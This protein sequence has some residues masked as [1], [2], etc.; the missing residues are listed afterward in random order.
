MN[1]APIRSILNL[2]VLALVASTAQAQSQDPNPY[3]LT[4][5]QAF[6]HESNVRRVTSDLAQGDDIS[7]TTLRAGVDQRIGRQRVE[8]AATV[9]WVRFRRD[10]T[11]DNTGYRVNAQWDWSTIDHL[12]GE[13]GGDALQQL[14]RYDTSTTTALTDRNLEKT[15]HFFARARYGVVTEWTLLAEL[16][17]LNRQFSADS[18]ASRNQRRDTAQVGARYQPTPDL[19]FTGTLRRAHGEYPDY[20]T[21]QGADSYDRT[22]Y[23]GAARWQVSGASLLDVRLAWSV[24]DHSQQSARTAKLWSGSAGWT[25]QPT[26]KL[27]L[28]TR[29][30]RD[31]DTGSES[32][33]QGVLTSFSDARQS[34]ALDANLTWLATSKIRAYTSLRM[35]RRDLDGSFNG[36]LLTQTGKDTT[37]LWS[38]GVSYQVLRNAQLGC[39]GSFEQRKA[40]GNYLGLTYPYTAKVASCSAVVGW[41]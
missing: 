11:L 41:F 34:T 4:L 35:T 5:G 18:Y 20:S 24:E 25:W 3:S 23:E 9:D 19:A 16:S 37:K 8:A 7:T 39:T 30:I 36:G 13:L 17:N 40:S 31:S 1:T 38:A 28:T 21:T 10:S 27:T 32:I 29:V 22:D 6:A 33:S 12:E 14:Y 26:G 2:A 15:Q